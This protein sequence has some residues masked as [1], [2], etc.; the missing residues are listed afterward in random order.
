MDPANQMEWFVVTCQ[1]F[2]PKAPARRPNRDTYTTEPTLFVEPPHGGWNR[3]TNEPFFGAPPPFPE[4][5]LI[6]PPL[7]VT[8]LTEDIDTTMR[9]RSRFI[10]NAE[11][12]ANDRSNAWTTK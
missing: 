3:A 5:F 11:E 2:F 8:V 9:M 10:I 7:Q 12:L 4:P 1:P 6:M